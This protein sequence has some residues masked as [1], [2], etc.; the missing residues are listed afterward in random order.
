[1]HT[2]HHKPEPTLCQVAGRQAEVAAAEAK[3]DTAAREIR[4]NEIRVTALQ[5]T[6]SFV[7]LQFCK[8][9]YSWPAVFT[10]RSVLG[11][12]QEIVA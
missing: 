1:M 3:I 11:L 6:N 7:C 8:S 9:V 10:D 4:E 2:T 5:V 12:S